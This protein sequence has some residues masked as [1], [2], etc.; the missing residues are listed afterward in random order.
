MQITEYD[1]LAHANTGSG[2]TAAYLLPIIHRINKIKREAPG[3]L[4]LNSESPYM[5]IISPTRE[6]ANQLY[7]DACA[8][9]I[10]N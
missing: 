1:M 5:I 8:F 9:S 2:K 7:E 6:L 4:I 3:G 10:G